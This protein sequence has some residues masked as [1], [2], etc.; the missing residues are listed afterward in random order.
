MTTKQEIL[1]LYEI[2]FRH[3]MRNNPDANIKGCMKEFKSLLDRFEEEIRGK[4]IVIRPGEKLV[5]WIE[6]IK[7]REEQEDGS[8]DAES[9]EGS[10]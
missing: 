5:G 6:P 2:A 7:D 3:A 10:N 9:H 8:Q 4:Q 1:D